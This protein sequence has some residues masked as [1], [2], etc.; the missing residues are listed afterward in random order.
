MIKNCVEKLN[1]VALGGNTKPKS[2]TIFQR[3]HAD[4]TLPNMAYAAPAVM[5]LLLRKSAAAALYR[6]HGAT[7]CHRY[8]FPAT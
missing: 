2:H 1:T 3:L 7:I 5:L 4:K 6:Q 8:F